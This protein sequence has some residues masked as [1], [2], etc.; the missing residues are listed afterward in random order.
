M[1]T[2]RF[3]GAW[4]T[5]PGPDGRTRAHNLYRRRV[6]ACSLTCRPTSTT[7]S[8]DKADTAQ[9]KS[10]ARRDGKVGSGAKALGVRLP[11]AGSRATA[12]QGRGGACGAGVGP[13]GRGR[14]GG[15]GP[16]GRGGA[17]R[18]RCSETATFR[19]RSSEA[20]TAPRERTHTGNRSNNHTV[21]S[22]LS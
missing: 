2:A 8:D 1:E 18:P 17:Q 6:P 15:A 19:G 3:S 12:H 7:C 22:G 20:N 10:G 21:T 11:P 14:R 13:A 5:R 9:L 4:R 16:A